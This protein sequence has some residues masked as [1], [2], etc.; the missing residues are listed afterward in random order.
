MNLNIKEDGT[1]STSNIEEYIYEPDGSKWQH[2]FH[3]VNPASIVFTSTDTFS[4]GVYKDNDRW[5]NFNICNKINSNWE[6]LLIQQATFNSELQKYR[7]IQSSNPLTATYADVAAAAITKN[8]SGYNTSGSGYGGI[9]NNSDGGKAYLIANNGNNGNWWGAIGSWSRF[10]GGIP[11]YSSVVITTGSLD[12][13]IRVD[14]IPM[15]ANISAL[16]M[17]QAQSFYEY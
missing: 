7:W 13:Y 3:H 8:T 5:F 14:N 15:Y 9:Y 10:N 6:I 2:V 16:N 1:L 12:V 17:T 11:G 4:T